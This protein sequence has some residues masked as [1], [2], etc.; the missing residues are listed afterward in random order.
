MHNSLCTD[1]GFAGGARVHT[2][3][4]TRR[5]LVVWEK[6]AKVYANIINMPGA[7]CSISG[8]GTNQRHKGLSLFK[9][10]RKDATKHAEWRSQLLGKT[11][12]DREMD[13]GLKK[14]IEMGSLHVCEKHFTDDCIETCKCKH[15]SR[16]YSFPFLTNVQ[17]MAGSVMLSFDLSCSW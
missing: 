1:L 10:P 7:N 17:Y 14:Q 4:C 3:K 11:L 16:I 12:R 9:I 6:F 15:L 5:S 2:S 13:A 8:C